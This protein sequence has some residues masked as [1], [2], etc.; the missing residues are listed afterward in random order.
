M[1]PRERL[2]M[3]EDDTPLAAKEVGCLADLG[4]QLVHLVL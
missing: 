4:A 1:L 2:Q 3:A